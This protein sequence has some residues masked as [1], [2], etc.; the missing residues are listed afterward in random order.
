MSIGRLE[1]TLTLPR[2]I[3][4]SNCPDLITMRSLASAGS[5]SVK[6]VGGFDAARI[7]ALRERLKLSQ[8]VLAAVLNTS[9]STVRKWEGGDKSPSGPS[10]RLLDLIERK[11]LKAVL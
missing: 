11:G 9:P 7:K 2:E 8:A 10:L 3:N 4:V 1:W 5:L 6:P